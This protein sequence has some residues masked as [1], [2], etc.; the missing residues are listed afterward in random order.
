MVHKNGHSTSVKGLVVVALAMAIGVTWLT[1]SA[2][3]QPA[4]V[5]NIIAS[6]PAQLSSQY[7]NTTDALGPSPFDN[8]KFPAPPWKWCHS[9]SYQGN[10]WRVSV[11]NELRRLVDNLKQQGL[12]SSFEMA[13]SNGDT[14]QQ[15]AQIRAFIDKGCSIIT[16]IPGSPTA[17]NGAIEAAYKAGIPFVTAAGA[18]TSPY[19]LNVDSNYV[20]WGY[21]MGT[22]LVKA[23][24]GNANII[25]V[26]GIAGNPITAQEKQGLDEALKGH[27]GMKIVRRVNGNW[28][29][30]V[31]KSVVLQA[32]ATTPQKI[33]GVWTTGSESRVIAQDFAQAGRP[34]PLITGSTSG[35]ALGY[36]KE[37]PD[38]YHFEGGAVLPSWT[39]QTLFRAGVRLLQGQ[40]P[41]LNVLMIPIPPVHEADLGSWYAS[42]MKPDSVSVFPVPPTDPM[43]TSL[44][45][46]YFAQPKSIGFNYSATPNPCTGQ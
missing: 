6:L 34:A 20:R 10:P 5:A 4:S 40:Q 32:L 41:K 25:E 42:C 45:N 27:P 39:A 11:T 18:V 2:L 23:F 37:N 14:S 24:N 7:A 9:E 21:D 43:P 12:V 8:F 22:A 29:P 17:L 35:D 36:W 30:S 1:S 44:F 33:D 19:A 46:D 26:D 38:K 13:D 31:T 15:I 16:S 3:A 28:T